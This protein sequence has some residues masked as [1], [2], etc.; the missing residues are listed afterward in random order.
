MK[1]RK[2]R[3][4]WSAVCGMICLLLILLWVRSYWWHDRLHGR[5]FRANHLAAIASEYGLVGVIYSLGISRMDG[6]T[7]WRFECQRGLPYPTW[8]LGE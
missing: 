3:I 7:H 2:L 6:T 8:W 1:Y 5:G 4:A